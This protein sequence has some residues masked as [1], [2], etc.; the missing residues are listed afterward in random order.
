M[1]APLA[2]ALAIAVGIII[3]LGYFVPLPILQDVRS[4]LLG[5][6]V[7]IVG[8]ATLVGIINLVLVHLRKLAPLPGT[9]R[10]IYS[11]FLLISFVVTL[12]FGLWL[13]PAE[14]N[15]Q[16]VVTS[17]QMPIETSLVA[18]LSVSLTYG[19]FRLLQRRRTMQS[20]IFLASAILF[21]LLNSG[22]LSIL[23]TIPVLNGLMGFLNQVPLAGARGIL[24]GIA[25]GSLLTGLRVLVGADRPYS[26]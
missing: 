4:V 6:G 2:T 1:K 13:S 3:L 21:L 23:E 14:K 19:G 7:T 8:F 18:V 5:W 11:L 26:G 24:L 16:H 15:F 10:D 22:V 12:I 25:L 17:I 9:K 20:I